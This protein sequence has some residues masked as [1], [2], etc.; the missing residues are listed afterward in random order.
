MS[1]EDLE[2]SGDVQGSPASRGWL[3]NWDV[4]DQRKTSFWQRLTPPQL[5]VGSFL[6]LIAIGTL[7]LKAL[8]GLYTGESLGWL[9]ALFT[10]VSAVCVTGLIVVDTATYFTPTGQAFILL[11]IQL[12]GLGMITFTTVIIAA[13]G[14]RL[15]LRQQS[16]AASSAEI[17]PDLDYRRLTRDV[18]VF[19]LA[20]E[21]VGA[22]L[23]YLL[24]IPRFGWGGAAWPALFHSI[25]AF[26]NAG[27]STFTDSLTGFRAAPYTLLVIMALIVVGGIGFLVLEELYLR[28]RTGEAGR[29]FRISLHTRL[30]LATTAVLIVGGWI[31]FTA[32][33]W[34]ITFAGMPDRVKVLNGLFLSVTARTGGFN[35]IDYGEA[36][37]NTNFLTM[38]LMFVGGSPGSTAGGLKTTTIALVALLAW[39]RFRGRVVV[40]LWDRSIRDESVQRAVGLVVVGVGLVTAAIFVYTTSEIGA[41]G[42]AGVARG[43]LAYAFEAVSAINTVG[44]TMGVTAGLSPFGK[45]FTMLLMFLGRVGP[46]TFAAALALSASPR[47]GRIRNAYEDVVVG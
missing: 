40:H 31:L 29:R 30:V 5:F 43:F 1:R 16:L 6:L 2:A 33:E 12:G 27:F 34:R 7:G 20:L 23:L 42:H 45:V 35:T 46:I 13:L 37:A 38:L 28:A 19:T 4:V 47:A 18:V 24:W 17:I 39:S 44:L 26:C 8:P 41:V 11:L 14:R 25:S 21:A 9:D 15:S 10:A 22:V 3:H 32:F 36:A